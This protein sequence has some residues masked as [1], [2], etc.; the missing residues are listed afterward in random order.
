[1]AVRL[2][3]QADTRQF[4]HLINVQTSNVWRYGFGGGQGSFRPK[5]LP[6][7]ISLVLLRPLQMRKGQTCPSTPR[8]R[9]P[10][11]MFFSFLAPSAP[12]PWA[13]VTAPFVL[14][15]SC[16]NAVK[17]K[18]SVW[19]SLSYGGDSQPFCLPELHLRWFFSSEDSAFNYTST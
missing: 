8:L 11:T 1:M 15:I 7:L 17:A 5:L 13:F 4:E 19:V 16:N 2:A 12:S 18:V 10:I 14:V 6:G 9:F 3:L